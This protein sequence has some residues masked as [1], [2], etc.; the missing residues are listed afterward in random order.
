V[1]DV[2]MYTP[3]FSRFRNPLYSCG[4]ERHDMRFT[5]VKCGSERW[6]VERVCGASAEQGVVMSGLGR[7]GARE[8]GRAMG[9]HP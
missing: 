3:S 6:S 8:A 1:R 9:P 5:R 4:Q 2:T 7:T